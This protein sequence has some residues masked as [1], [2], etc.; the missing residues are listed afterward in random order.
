MR[1]ARHNA[2][3]RLSIRKIGVTADTLN[4]TLDNMNQMTSPI[5]KATPTIVTKL[6]SSSANST[7]Y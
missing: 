1:R 3:A 7:R 6:D 4:G 2:A 5:A